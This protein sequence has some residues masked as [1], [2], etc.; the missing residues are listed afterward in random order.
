MT[1]TVP[2]VAVEGARLSIP[3]TTVAD[4][5]LAQASRT[6][7]AVAVRQW[8]ERLTY[9]E[10]VARAAG[11]A[12]VLRAHGVGPQT[13]VGVCAHR[14]PESVAVVLGVLLAGGCYVPME[15]GGPRARLLEI[16]VD[17]GVSIVIGDAAVAEFGAVEGIRAL[18]VPGPAA[19]RPCPATPADTAHVLYTSGSTGKPKGVLTTHRNVVAFVTG[20]AALYG[21]GPDTR[22]LGIASLGFDATTVDLFVPLTHGGSVQ[23]LGAADRADPDRLRRFLVAHE[24]NWGFITPTMLSVLDPADVPGW[25]LIAC[26][27]EAMPPELARRWAPGR[28]LVNGY[29][30]TETTVIVV[31]GEVTE[32]ITDPV[33][34]GRPTPNHRAYVVAPD[35]LVP[36][37]PGEVGEL[38]IGGPGVADGYLGRPELTAAAFVD[39]PLRPGERL[40]RTGDLARVRADGRI[41][42]LG[43][44]DRQVKVRG[45]RI[46]LGEVEAGLAAHPAVE[47]VAVEAVTGAGGTKLVAFVTPET[48]PSD[49]DLRAH[50]ATRLTAAMRPAVIRRVPALPVNPVSGKV[51]RP[52]LRE[53]A[54]RAAAEHAQLS[55]VDTPVGRAVAAIWRRVLGAGAGDDF[56]RAGGDSIAAMR[57]VAALRAE[58]GADVGVRDVFEG[59]TLAGVTSRV[60]AAPAL[61]GPELSRGNPPTLAPP[62]RRLWFL[63][64]LAPDAAPYNIAMAYRLDGEV[65]HAALRAALRAVAH[66]HEVLRWRIRAVDGVPTAEL[67]PVAD[68]D[69]PVVDTTE[70]ELDDRLAADAA[71][72]LHL[73]RESPWRARLYRLGATDHVLGLTLH[74]AVFDGW[75]QSVLC[76]DLAAAYRGETLVPVEA[77]YAD[78]AVWRAERDVRREAVDLAW[79]TGHLRGAP[80]TLDLPRDHPRPAVQTYR[81]ASLAV[82][83]PPG[84]A[85]AVRA[86]AAS[87]GTTVASVL[88]AAFG[89]VLHRLTG[90]DDQLVATVVAD[91]QLAPCADVAGFFVDIVPV[92]LR[93]GDAEAADFAT[94]VRRCADELVAATAHP[95]APIDRLVGA[96]DVPRDPARA[97]LVQVMFNVLNFAEPRLDLPGVRA[98][99]VP[100]RKP[101]SPFDVT[102]YVQDDGIELL[103][104]PD[105][106]ERP[107]IAALAEDYLA[108]VAAL[109]AAPGTPVHAVEPA[110]P[111]PEVRTPAAEAT[112]TRSAPARTTVVADPAALATTEAMLLA[113]WREVLGLAAVKVTD[114]FFDVGGHSLALAEVHAK[115]CARLGR[116]VPLVD[117]F[118]HP[119]IRAFATHLH[120]AE[121]QHDQP[122]PDLARAAQRVA[123]RLGR[124]Q[125]RRPRRPAGTAGQ[126]R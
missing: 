13:R 122:N 113:V 24:V 88:L 21:A 79:W 45:Q 59:A 18:D 38:L 100:V 31:T 37:L 91:R 8:D 87:T 97:P 41:E 101:G 43:R 63:D 116:Q 15:P 123:A 78:Y 6:P 9:R 20:W 14:R 11:V 22:A 82:P 39:D 40:Y 46:E 57:L 28:R 103:Y 111:R 62:Q 1:N 5:V 95:A 56:F 16:A 80:T 110:L 96:L 77:S 89:Q 23:L 17:A 7:D 30:P 105:L 102:V 75:S 72:P 119:N 90:T 70:A 32:P 35:S 99:W 98:S 125:Q 126:E 107:R 29:G 34:L 33:P 108:L 55:E 19:P 4:L 115:V 36:V 71:T 92:R 48:A 47:A 86:L 3:D 74:H 106:F 58:L 85:D 112:A 26:G 44:A 10:L 93:C 2:A 94:H 68:V 120:A 49:D 124:T 53:L 83:M 27:G 64:Q 81:G 54:A 50:A 118:T 51:D 12:E 104:N 109:A 67:T 117:L 66:R 60:A 25:E 52:A 121:H 65:D 76:T 69:L 73:D 114:N 84:A 42:Y 61:D